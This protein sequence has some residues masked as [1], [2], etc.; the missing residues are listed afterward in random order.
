MN[1]DHIHEELELLLPDFTSYNQEW[2]TRAP[3]WR[4]YYLAHDQTVH[5]DYLKTALKI[6]Q[7]YRPRERWVL[8]SPQH[9][10]QL[11]ALQQALG[12]HHLARRQARQRRRQAAGSQRMLENGE[13]LHG[14]ELAGRQLGLPRS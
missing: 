3:R 10:E 13:Q 4:D 12:Q 1:P 14:R 7:W 9:L 11:G 5:Y 2:V 6:L 8:K